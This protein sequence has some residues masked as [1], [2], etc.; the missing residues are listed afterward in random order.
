MSE[1]SGNTKKK[2]HGPS[3][4]VQ[5]ATRMQMSTLEKTGTVAQKGLYILAAV[6]IVVTTALSLTESNV[7]SEAFGVLVPRTRIQII[8]TAVDGTVDRY[9]VADGQKVKQGDPLIL[10]NKIRATSDLD[11]QQQQLESL[12]VQRDE[13][14]QASKAL[15]NIIS[16]PRRLAGISAALPEADRIVG[17]VYSAKKAL[18]RAIYDATA[19]SS[20]ADLS[21]TSEMSGLL[22][23]KKSMEAGRE[24]RHQA[25]AVRT[26]E[27]AALARKLQSRVKLLERELSKSQAVLAEQKA[28][29]AD[30]NSELEIFQKG[31][32]LGVASGVKYLNVQSYVHQREYA[33]LQTETQ[34]ASTEQQLGAAKMDLNAAGSSYKA[35]RADMMAAIKSDDAKIIGVPL[36]I[37]NTAK[38]LDTKE[39]AFNVASYHARAHLAKEV[40]EMDTLDRKISEATASIELLKQLMRERVIKSPIDGIVS[41]RSH[42]APAEMVERGQEL[43]SVVPSGGQLLVRAHVRSADIGFVKVG[44]D[45]RLRFEAFPCEE[46]GV[47][48]GKVEQVGAYPEVTK[49]DQKKISTYRVDISPQH[50]WIGNGAHRAELKIGMNVRADIVVRKRSMLMLLL[51]PFFKTDS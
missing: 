45:A 11:K 35:D 2:E 15:Q 18:D 34:I 23:E 43:M 33:V 5:I 40:T 37:N 7:C 48:N 12:Q 22:V 30:A 39:A 4:Y 10:L 17:E 36:S 50:D 26:N 13:H 38:E 21:R 6:L 16:N 28:S 24:A 27:H 51:A 1:Q 3:G 32:K 42:L 14:Q 41:Q 49:K 44:Q 8:R 25:V 46:F 29:L 20:A 47:N 19:N 9:L 31:L